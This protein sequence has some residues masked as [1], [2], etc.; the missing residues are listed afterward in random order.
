MGYQAGFENLKWLFA[1]EPALKHPNPDESFVI[2]AD[3]S[4]V[5]VGT[6]LFQNSPQGVLQPCAYICRKLSEADCRWVVWEKEAYAV[7]WSLITWRHLLKDTKIP[8]ELWL[9]HK[10]LGALRMS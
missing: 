6:V 5:A 4:D 3:T 9:D 2:Q 7:R 1:A 8:F 10:N